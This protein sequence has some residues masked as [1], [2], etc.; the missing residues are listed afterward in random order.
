VLPE[1]LMCR[2]A[3]LEH[4]SKESVLLLQ[5]QWYGVDRYANETQARW[6]VGRMEK[7]C[8]PYVREMEYNFLLEK[9]ER[10]QLVLSTVKQLRVIDMLDGL[11]AAEMQS[12]TASHPVYTTFMYF[13][14]LIL[15]ILSLV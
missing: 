7:T 1:R 5:V 13:M 15:A 14:S 11:P 9:A 6:H 4:Y 8:A 10:Y 12:S 3:V 2:I